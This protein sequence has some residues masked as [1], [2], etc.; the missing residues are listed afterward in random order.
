LSSLA[1]KA[2][3]SASSFGESSRTALLI[4][5]RLM[6]RFYAYCCADTM[7][8]RAAPEGF[9]RVAAIRNHLWRHR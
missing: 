9:E 8:L 3:N 6:V 1:T 4:S 5:A 7:G 2:A